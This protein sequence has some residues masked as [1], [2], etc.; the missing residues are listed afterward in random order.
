MSTTTWAVKVNE[1]QKQLINN[2]LERVAKDKG[3]NKRDS[4][5]YIVD[6]FSKIQLGDTTNEPVVFK[7]GETLLDGDCYYLDYDGRN[8]ICR[9]TMAEK[10]EVTILGNNPERTLKHCLACKQDEADKIREDRRRDERI[11]KLI[12][13]LLIDTQIKDRRRDERI[14]KLIEL[15]HLALQEKLRYLEKET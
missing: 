2:T 4:L 11:K 7:I 6:F 13:L 5:V 3:L 8:F 15:I 12:E 14:K 1:S 9:A 10:K